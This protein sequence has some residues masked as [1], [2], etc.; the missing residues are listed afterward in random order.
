MIEQ[1]VNVMEGGIIG[2]FIALTLTPKYKR[3]KN[4]MIFGSFVITYA[5][6]V[7]AINSMVGNEQYIAIIYY[8]LLLIYTLCAYTEPLYTKMI[9]CT[10]PVLILIL[11]ALLT[12]A[13]IPAVFGVDIMHTFVYGTHIR[14]VS[15]FTAKC[16]QLFLTLAMISIV[17]G[18]YVVFGKKE[19]LGIGAI[20]FVLFFHTIFVYQ[21]RIT[22]NELI[23]ADMF[24]A[25]SVCLILAIALLLYFFNNYH[26]SMLETYELRAK[27]VAWVEQVKHA[28][29][30]EVMYEKYLSL[31]HDSIHQY[32]VLKRLLDGKMYGEVDHFAEEMLKHIHSISI[33]T[34]TFMLK[35]QTLNALLHIY[36]GKMKSNDI[37][38]EYFIE[39]VE[40]GKIDSYD[41]CL[42]LSNLLENAMEATAMLE[43]KSIHV[44]L[45][46]KKG[47]IDVKVI[48]TIHTSVLASNATLTTTKAQKQEH[49]FGILTMKNIVHKYDGS[50]EVY[51]EDHKI[52]FHILLKA[53]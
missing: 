16:I 15:L 1:L 14:E 38:V 35:N 48:N 27:Q 45:K 42:L 6:I 20:I 13:M 52:C 8:I 21:M 12:G 33:G 31:R 19:G 39:D 49:G 32:E 25:S 22:E 4:I 53:L 46:K 11:S 18:K 10:I 17:K 7:H 51:E 37:K 3:A 9:Y 36:D 28:E 43:D 40:L 47:Y 23:K 26:K 2:M 44:A 41:V 34:R 30:M 24:L 50:F 29:E 5:I